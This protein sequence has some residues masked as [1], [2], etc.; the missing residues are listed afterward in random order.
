MSRVL[1]GPLC[2][3]TLG[4]L[5]ADVIK[6]E[7]P[8]LGDESRQWGPPFDD[9]GESAYYLS[10]N[11]NKL[12]ITIDL[13]SSADVEMLERLIAESDVVLDNFKAETLARA[14]LKRDALLE[15]HPRL[16]WLTLSGFGAGN[17]RLGYDLVVQA[18]SGWMSIT[19][20]VTGEP[21]KVGVALADVIAGKDAAL[22]I[23]AAIVARER[24]HEALP[25]SARRLDV[26]LAHSA[27]AALVN[28]AQ[29]VLV[30]GRE[31]SRFGNAHPNLVPYQAFK[32]RDGYIVIGVGNDRQWA[33]CCAALE[34]PELSRDSE[35][36]TNTG[37]LA[38]RERVTTAIARR[39][40]EHDAEDCL[41]RLSKRGVPAGR[42]RPVSQALS[43]VAH[44][45]LTGI[46]PARPGTVRFPPPRLNEH[47]EAI[48]RLGWGAFGAR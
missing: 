30:S 5:G 21:M 40:A 46:A 32:A 27:I 8:G 36:A 33:G 18:E 7:R 37:R 22:A 4:D 19:G 15:A 35:L 10:T 1:A 43:D 17:P 39:V 16:V 24:S 31:A 42:V 25:V 11:R 13:D 48:R 2:G 9:R 20:E 41:S 34:L 26:S 45:A 28:V 14:G 29:N 23:M 12:G 6:V 3:M 44:S 47:G 38:N